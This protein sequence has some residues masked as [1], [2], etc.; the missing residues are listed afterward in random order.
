M[1]PFKLRIT[2]SASGIRR[3]EFP[4]TNPNGKR[5]TLVIPQP[6]PSRR[7]QLHVTH[8]RDAEPGTRQRRK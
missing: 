4:G 6:K 5:L 1:R 3:I 8:P 7:S 2:Y